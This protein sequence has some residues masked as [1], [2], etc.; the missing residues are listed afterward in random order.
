MI[1]TVVTDGKVRNRFGLTDRDMTTIW[2]I[3]GRYPKIKTV[4]VFGS[5]AKGTYKS[6]SDID[7]VIMDIGVGDSVLLKLNEVF[8]DSSLPYF[9]DLIC[10]PALENSALK[11]HID[12][13]GIPF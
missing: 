10:Y 4:I 11:E 9:V 12:R 6:G 5:R 3:L 7:L 13:V 2:D 1:S 8:S